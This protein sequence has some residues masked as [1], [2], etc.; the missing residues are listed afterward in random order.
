[1]PTVFLSGAMIE[2]E[3]YLALQVERIMAMPIYST[4]G[5]EAQSSRLVDSLHSKCRNAKVGSISL[6]IAN[7]C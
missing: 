6:I 5:K 2:V 3:K 1:M 4:L 7:I